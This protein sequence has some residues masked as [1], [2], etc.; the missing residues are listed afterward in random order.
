ME[1]ESTVNLQCITT[2]ALVRELSSRP[3]VRKIIVDAYGE[4]TVRVNGPAIL[5]EIID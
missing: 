4:K 1:Q 3:G 5:L 2:A